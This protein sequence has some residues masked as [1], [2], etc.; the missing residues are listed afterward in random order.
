MSFWVSVDQ[1]DYVKAVQRLLSQY[2]RYIYLKLDDDDS[3]LGK[4]PDRIS[5]GAG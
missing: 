4:K 5:G 3:M 2:S 1:R